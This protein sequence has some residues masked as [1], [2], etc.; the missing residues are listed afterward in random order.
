MIN[1][2]V[3]TIAIYFTVTKIISARDSLLPTIR[4]ERAVDDPQEHT[5]QQMA[6]KRYQVSGNII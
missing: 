3:W 5:D 4:E 6:N 1:G 2:I